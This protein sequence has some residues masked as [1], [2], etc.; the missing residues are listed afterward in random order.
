[1]HSFEQI[2]R[3]K[4]I[5]L[6]DAQQN[7]SCEHGELPSGAKSWFERRQG[8]RADGGDH[9]AIE[10][11]RALAA[12][13]K[14]W[15]EFW[16]MPRHLESCPVCLDL[17][18]ALLDDD[19][20]V[21]QDVLERM[22]KLHPLRIRFLP[23]LRFSLPMLAKTAAAVAVLAFAVLLAHEFIAAP[24]VRI[25]DGSLRLVDGQEVSAGSVAPIGS[26]LR[27][28]RPTTTVFSDGSKVTASKD[29]RMAL[30]TSLLRDKVVQLSEGRVVCVVSKQKAGRGFKVVTPAGEIVVVGTKFSVDSRSNRGE[31]T[32]QQRQSQDEGGGK[33][34][35]E[36]LFYHPLQVGVRGDDATDAPRDSVVT[37]TVDEGVVLV[38]NRSG[39]ESRVT[40][41]QTAVLRSG[42][43]V[44]D[45][46]Q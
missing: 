3:N 7:R 39:K 38:R 46:F 14:S 10:E 1:M 33:R 12:D 44:I 5:P 19:K 6:D 27:V 34:G 28:L 4:G 20:A 21:D 37:V 43:S 2:I 9:F 32:A 42:M 30:L 17:F 15:G 23:R 40:A 13:R 41:G 11:L 29:S 45:V 22:R 16:E 36:L 24:S 26:E 25:I 31:G 8:Q 18:E 35:K